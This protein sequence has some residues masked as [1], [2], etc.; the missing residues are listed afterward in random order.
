MQNRLS[1][2]CHQKIPGHVVE[3]CCSPASLNKSCFSQIRFLDRVPPPQFRE[4]S[5]HEVQG[6]HSCETG[7]SS[8]L[9]NSI[10][11]AGPGQGW[12]GFSSLPSGMRHCRDRFVV[13][14]PQLFEQLDHSSHS[15]HSWSFTQLS[16]LQVFVSDVSPLKQQQQ[17]LEKQKQQQQQ[18]QQ[19]FE[20]QQKQ[21][22]QSHGWTMSNFTLYQMKEPQQIK[23]Y[24]YNI[25]M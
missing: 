10:T 17:L 13:P 1:F 5:V 18:Q 22:Q 24:Y 11:V 15:V 6:V 16:P 4:H 3:D 21:Q 9:Q 25:I 8:R 20:K 23:E 2:I 19:Q 7:Q 12:S 14:P